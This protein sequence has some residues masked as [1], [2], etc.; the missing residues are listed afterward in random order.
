MKA[1]GGYY[2]IDKGLINTN[3][4]EHTSAKIEDVG[5]PTLDA[6]NVVQATPW[7]INQ[8]VLDTMIKAWEG[9]LQVGELPDPNPRPLPKIDERTWKCMTPQER[10]K[11]REL[12]ASI[13]KRNSAA[14]SG[15]L[16]LVRKLS[17]AKQLAGRP[18]WF[19]HYLDFRG[20]VYP[21]PQDLNPQGDDWARGL[22]TF[23]TAKSLGK[24]GLRWLCIHIANTYGMDKLSFDERVAWVEEHLDE[25]SQTAKRPLGRIMEWW[26]TCDQ[27]F[28][29]L[30]ACRELEAAFASSSP[31]SFASSLPVSLDGSC[32]GLQHLSLMGLDPVGAKA[33]NCGYAA[34]RHD[35][36][37]TVANSVRDTL[38]QDVESGSDD[39]SVASAWLSLGVTRKTVKRAVMTTPYGVTARG[40]QRQL[41]ADGHMDDIDYNVPEAMLY[42]Q[43]TIQKAIDQHV[44]AAKEIMAYFQ[45][46]AGRLAKVDKPLVWTT[47]SGFKV[48]QA[49]WN[50]GV[51]QVQTLTGRMR[52]YNEDSELRMNVAKQ[53]LGSAPNIIHSFDAAML[54]MT[55]NR[56]H[57]D[58]G[59]D[60][61]MMI[62][63]SYGT[64]A[65]NVELMADA[66]RNTAYDIYKTDRLKAFHKGLEAGVVL[67]NPPKR[68]DFNIE[69]VK[70]ALY[71]FA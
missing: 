12:R 19:P 2:L 37:E 10:G 52:L 29:F 35:L 68:R 64:H 47:P 14:V 22:L 6:L 41:L 17:L 48:T 42:M 34:K 21:M 28:Q 60:H 1:S 24:S 46:C 5:Q 58:L 55:V 8:P 51:K 15:R 57:A 33:T 31:Q 18:I 32:N 61:F 45:E 43:R 7:S 23:A 44:V 40:I 59:I 71:F 56:L 13:H 3:L 36:Y 25:I 30:A 39:A 65:A 9:G 38:R 27:P 63:D 26:G 53:R 49:Y 54:A 4:W 20:R 69:E 16:S 66:I 67:P 70:H 50:L 62:H 11:H